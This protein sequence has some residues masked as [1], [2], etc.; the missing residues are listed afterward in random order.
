MESLLAGLVSMVPPSQRKRVDITVRLSNAEFKATLTDK[1]SGE[2]KRLR[3][4]MEHAVSNTEEYLT[5]T[6][7]LC[8]Y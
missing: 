6:L 2:Y 4:S 3:N 7:F 8:Y 1:A 5:L